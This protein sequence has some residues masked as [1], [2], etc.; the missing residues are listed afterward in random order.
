MAGWW[1][2]LSRRE[3]LLIMI[4]VAALV[5]VILS[6]G[7]LR[8]LVSYR[9][10]GRVSLDTAYTTAML[11]DQAV[12]TAGSE[13]PQS[14]ASGAQL[15]GIVTGYANQDN[16][17]VTAF[18]LSQSGASVIISIEN[19]SSSQL[20]AWLGRLAD[21]RNITVS[22]ARITPARSGGTSVQARLTLTQGA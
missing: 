17:P 18:Q 13:N 22:E 19:I 5:A 16:I 14:G 11:V 7:V 6:L 8:P 9:D 1:Q 4:M 15:R 10:A 3:H 12:A 20:F 2:T 21:E